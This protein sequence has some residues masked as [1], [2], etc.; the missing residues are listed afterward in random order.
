MDDSSSMG[1]WQQISL[2]LKSLQWHQDN[3]MPRASTQFSIISLYISRARYFLKDIQIMVLN[4]YNISFFA[5]RH[6]D[7][8]SFF[9]LNTIIVFLLLKKIV[10]FSTTF[11]FSQSLASEALINQ[12]YNCVTYL[13]KCLMHKFLQ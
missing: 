1:N 10:C 13:S 2:V 12:L 3:L 6:W 4:A 11:F 7:I 5:N 9:S 8:R